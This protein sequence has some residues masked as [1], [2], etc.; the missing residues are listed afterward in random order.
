MDATPDQ[1]SQVSSCACCG[2]AATQRWFV[3]KAAQG[4]WW[5]GTCGECALHVAQAGTHRL[6]GAVAAG[7]VGLA[8]SFGIP[9]ARP[10]WPLWLGLLV[11]LL[12]ASVFWCARCLGLR[13]PAGHAAR[14]AALRP[15]SGTQLL[16]ASAAFAGELTAR[17]AG[18]SRPGRFRAWS[19]GAEILVIW[20]ALACLAPVSY[21]HHHP[22]LRVLNF[23]EEPF[24]LFVDGRRLGRVEPSRR[25]SPLAGLSLRVPAGS[26]SL[27][28]V[29]PTGGKSALLTRE[30]Q[31]GR[32]H[33]YVPLGDSTCFWLET[34]GHGR[35]RRAV[36]HTQLVPGERFWVLPDSLH[37]LFAPSPASEQQSRATGGRTSVLRQGA[38]DAPPP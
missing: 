38:C 12:G 3:G 6:A 15:L 20:A 28:S 22:R 24:E 33:L 14:G 8:L 23:G 2:A 7:L 37:G 10:W 29:D 19:D 13:A 27:T 9:I 1:L 18:K 34:V 30:L 35:E 16:C 11:S 26:R 21:L 17:G 25:E 32:H 4:E 36:E 31:A 5:A